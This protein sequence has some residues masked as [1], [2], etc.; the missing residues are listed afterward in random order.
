METRLME[1]V[2]D[3]E[4]AANEA[5]HRHDPVV[6]SGAYVRTERRGRWQAL[7]GGI[8]GVVAAI[9]HAPGR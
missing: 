7:T 9:I 1:L 2:L 5:R 8:G 4:R 6:D 3:A